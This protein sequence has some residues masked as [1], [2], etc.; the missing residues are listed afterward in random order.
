MNL[1]QQVAGWYADAWQRARDVD[2]GLLRR[3]GAYV[4][5]ALL[6]GLVIYVLWKQRERRIYLENQLDIARAK[7]KGLRARAE[8][9]ASK[10]AADK[11]AKKAEASKKRADAIE[12][13]IKES[14]ALRRNVADQLENVDGW[15]SLREEYDKL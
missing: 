3:I 9:E 8:I 6:V 7:E 12:E 2:R 5:A 13:R 15:E 10:E 4:A 1:E 11:L 14:D